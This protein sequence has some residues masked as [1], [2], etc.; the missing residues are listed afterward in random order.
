M[1]LTTHC[2]SLTLGNSSYFLWLV[3]SI[4]F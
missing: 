2:G 3:Q 1:M 4:F